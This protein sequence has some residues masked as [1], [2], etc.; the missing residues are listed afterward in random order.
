[1]P[2]MKSFTVIILAIILTLAFVV[3]SPNVLP[4]NEQPTFDTSMT[5]R[6]IAHSMGIKGGDLAE[7]LGLARDVAKDTP[8]TEL[9]I[10]PE[11]LEKALAELPASEPV[12]ETSSKVEVTISMTLHEAAE[13]LGITGG[14]MA[15]SVGLAIDSD[16]NIPMKDLGVKPETLAEAVHHIEEEGKK[17]LDW[18]KYPFWVLIAGL[19]IFL[20]LKGKA[21]RKAYL[22]TLAASLAV[23]GFWLG[24]SPNPMES[25]VKL[26]K[27]AVGIFSNPLPLIL[28]FGFFSLLVIV[29]NKIIC[30]WGCP[31]GAL[32]E[33][34]FELPLGGK[35]KELRKKQL[36]FRV[37]NTVR[38][39]LFALFVLIIAGIGG[40]KK[41]TVIY[42]YI[43]PFNLFD[44]NFALI[45]VIVSIVAFSMVSIFVYRPFCQF[46]CPF[47]VV[48]WILERISLTKV[49]VDREACTE[50]RVCVSACPLEAMKGRL[51]QNK[52]PADCFSCARCLRSCDYDALHYRPF[53][54]KG[55]GVAS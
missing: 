31:F 52:A 10:T 43:N 8:L 47:G 14:D 24:K 2:T 49:T 18:I 34:L 6:E 22:W 44:Y 4:A 16:K 26:A 55:K 28:A 3:L 27:G 13:A 7:S 40:A 41:G 37:T 51:D 32:E 38:I 1:M 45:S 11:I 21:S 17:G 23:T 20:L 29:G 19:G 36:P 42:H 35:I 48:S 15:H 5:I 9:G 46:V 39:V 50:C 25:V 33:L 53:W 30:G 54:D 12:K